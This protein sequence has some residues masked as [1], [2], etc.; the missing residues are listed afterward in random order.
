MKLIIKQLE[1]VVYVKLKKKQRLRFIKL[2]LYVKIVVFKKIHVLYAI[3]VLIDF[4]LKN[5]KKVHNNKSL[6]SISAQA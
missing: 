5:T 3:L 6:I 4:L 2:V 1:T